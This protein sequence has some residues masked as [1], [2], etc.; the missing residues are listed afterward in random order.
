[1][2]PILSG[3]YDGQPVSYIAAPG[4][5]TTN[6]NPLTTLNPVQQPLFKFSGMQDPEQ[7]REA[8]PQSAEA[9]QQPAAAGQ[10]QTYGQAPT[11]NALQ[12]LRDIDVLLAPGAWQADTGF[13]YTHFSNDFPLALVDPMGDVVGV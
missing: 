4:G 13:V 10:E 11:N 1:G 3:A 2:L 9:G 5:P 7:K 12:F 6:A 8:A